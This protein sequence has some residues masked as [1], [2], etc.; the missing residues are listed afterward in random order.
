M[1]TTRPSRAAQPARATQPSPA[2]RRRARE[3]SEGRLERR[4]YFL[5]AIIGVVVLVI[6]AAGVIL[7]VVMPPRSTVVKVGDREFT[8]RDLATRLKYAVFVEQN[9]SVVTDPAGGIPVLTR[10]ELLR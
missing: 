7:T 10:E 5:A 8:A 9:S 1:A 6:V 4:I 2:A 3:A